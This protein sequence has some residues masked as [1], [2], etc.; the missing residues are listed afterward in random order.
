VIE[1]K[2]PHVIKVGGLDYPILFEPI[3]DDDGEHDNWGWWRN[4]PRMIKIHPEADDVRCST[5]FWHE[6]LHAIDDTI[7]GNRLTEQDTKNLEVG[8]H[9]VLE[10]MGVR[11]VK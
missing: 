2:I 7:L 11:F 1:I 10:Q 6:I 5:T 4:N 9:Q 8:I 3:P